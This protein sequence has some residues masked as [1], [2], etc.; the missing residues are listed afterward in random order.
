MSNQ[1][2]LRR[3]DAAT[4]LKNNHG[5]GSWQT[6]AKLAISGDGPAYRKFGRTVLYAP[7]DLDKWFEAKVSAPLR[8]TASKIDEN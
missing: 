6:L 3:K 2:Y 4:Y 8:S 1:G 5:I 7:S